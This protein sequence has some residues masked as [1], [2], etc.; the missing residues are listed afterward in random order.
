LWNVLLAARKYLP[1]AA[2]T[3]RIANSYGKYP[4][5]I[6]ISISVTR[7]F[8][9]LGHAT[10]RDAAFFCRQTPAVARAERQARQ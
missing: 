9:A 10:S 6:V 3:A 4:L 2:M 1:G 5:S 8:R 7:S